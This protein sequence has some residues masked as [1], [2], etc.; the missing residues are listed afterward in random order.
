MCAGL[1]QALLQRRGAELWQPG[2]DCV[3]SVLLLHFLHQQHILRDVHVWCRNQTAE[4]SMSWP[5]ALLRRS[6]CWVVTESQHV[7]SH[8]RLK[9]WEME[10][11]VM[12]HSGFGYE[13]IISMGWHLSYTHATQCALRLRCC[14]DFSKVVK[15]HI[16]A[17]F[18]DSNSKIRGFCMF[19]WETYRQCPKFAKCITVF[20]DKTLVWSSNKFCLKVF[21]LSCFQ[22]REINPGCCK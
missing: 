13:Q 14:Q 16:L 19:L 8:A 6:S 11:V 18:Q 2:P 9:C 17:I 15:L 22:I 12:G 20:S 7:S 1:V 21:T 5:T 3:T 4:L 10:A